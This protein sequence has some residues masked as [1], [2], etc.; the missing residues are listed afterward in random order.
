MLEEWRRQEGNEWLWP[1]HHPRNFL[2]P[3]CS[4][5]GAA[6][7]AIAEELVVLH[8]PTGCSATT[9][10]QLLSHALLASNSMQLLDF[11]PRFFFSLLFFK[12]AAPFC[13]LSPLPRLLSSFAAE[14]AALPSPSAS[15]KIKR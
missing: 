1:F 11:A 15:T 6:L 2:S 7:K 4:V 14:G 13:F 5:G 9:M 3:A 8:W 10:V 12:S